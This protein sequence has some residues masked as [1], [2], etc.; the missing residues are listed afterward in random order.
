[1]GKYA[2]L[3][4]SGSHHILRVWGVHPLNSLLVSC[5]CYVR[6]GTTVVLLR[7]GVLLAPRDYIHIRIAC[8]KLWR[9]LNAFTILFVQDSVSYLVW[10]VC[11]SSK[12]ANLHVPQPQDLCI[13]VLKSAP[14][15]SNFI[16]IENNR[17]KDF[18]DDKLK[19]VFKEKIVILI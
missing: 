9:N 13:S 18:E 10:D 2:Q 17:S 12:S 4:H 15:R 8:R 3:H 11:V 6:S 14:L 5:T 1:M 16:K 19:A 7:S